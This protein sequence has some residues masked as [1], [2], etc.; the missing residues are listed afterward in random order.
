MFSRRSDEEKNDI[1]TSAARSSDQARCLVVSPRFFGYENDICQEIREAGF[2][3]D[4]FDERPGNS[5]VVRA[6]LRVWPQLMNFTVSRYYRRILSQICGRRYS[7]VLVL[8]AEV[9][10]YW[11][12][13]EVRKENPQSRFV[14]YTYDSLR[15]SPNCLNVIDLFDKCFSFDYDDV[16]RNKSFE[17]M[18]LFFSRQFPSQQRSQVL[19]DLAFVGT[20][21]SDRYDEISSLFSSFSATYAFFY[22]QARWFYFFSKYIIRDFVSVRGSDV[23]FDKKSR[24]EVASI[25]QNSKAVVDIQRTGQTGLTMRTFEVLA[26]GAGLITTNPAVRYLAMNDP[27]RILILEDLRSPGAARAVGSFLKAQD[28]NTAMP[29]GFDAYSVKSWVMRIFAE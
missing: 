23:S 28:R 26:S 25:F 7:M 16:A 9:I 22:C 21:H 2:D 18:P 12:L 20:L 24:E 11:F 15:N 10:P 5:A 3:V 17:L 8:K 13:E 29:N 27:S 1:A 19:Y 6:I 4:F 14:F